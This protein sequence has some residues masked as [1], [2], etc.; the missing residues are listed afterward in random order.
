MENVTTPIAVPMLTAACLLLNVP[1]A[2][3]SN[4]PQP[5][6][7]I[8]DSELPQYVSF[9][10]QETEA[11]E[12]QAERASLSLYKTLKEELNVSHTTLAPWIGLKRRSMYNWFEDPSSTRNADEVE[13]R[14]SNLAAL[15]RDMEPEHKP[16]LHKVAFSPIDGDPRFGQALVDGASKEELM[17]WYDMLY[18]KFDLM[19]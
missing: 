15:V 8:Q 1:V 9:E 14:L 19:A 16:L 6:V 11:T 12:V 5:V 13:Q 7:V 2:V 18:D 10:S 17:H 4:T 3:A